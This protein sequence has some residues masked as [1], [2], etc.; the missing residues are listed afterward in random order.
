MWCHTVKEMTLLGAEQHSLKPTVQVAVVYWT[1]VYRDWT[2]GH[3]P[4]QD[5]VFQKENRI[6]L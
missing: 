4:S 1:V 3:S 2:L 5:V 6:V